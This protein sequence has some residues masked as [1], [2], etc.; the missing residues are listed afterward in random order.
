[1]N[2]VGIGNVSST[3]IFK[4]FSSNEIVSFSLDCISEIQG[5]SEIELELER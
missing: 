5:I 4:F 3:N 2:R 1:M